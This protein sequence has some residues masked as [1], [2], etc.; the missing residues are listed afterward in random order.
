MG[1]V[2]GAKACKHCQKVFSDV[3]LYRKHLRGCSKVVTGQWANGPHTVTSG[4]DGVIVCHC[5]N[6]RC[7]HEYLSVDGFKG[8]I[9]DRYEWK[10]PKV[11][12]ILA[13]PS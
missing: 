5:T 9:S 2:P 3:S 7:A 8:H 10:G 6:P 12:V 13:R 1:D 11:G 4:T